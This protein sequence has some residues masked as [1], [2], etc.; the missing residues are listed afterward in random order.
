MFHQ[1]TGAGNECSGTINGNNNLSDNATS[2]CP[3]VTTTLTIATVGPLADNGGSTMTHALLVGSEAIDAG[4]ANSTI[5]DQRGTNAFGPR[6]IGAYEATAYAELCP[7]ALQTDG[8]TT[9]VV[10]TAKLNQAIICA[11]LNGSGTDTINLSAVSYTHLTL[12]TIYS[13]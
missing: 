5:T 4:D 7:I 13:V 3:D 2:G 10:D 8:F 12:P 6:D 1:N 9:S 11:N